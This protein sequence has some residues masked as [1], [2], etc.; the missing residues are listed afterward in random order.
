[1]HQTA[2]HGDIHGT[3]DAVSQVGS[4][5]PSWKPPPTPA[6]RKLEPS[7]RPRPP[8]VSAPGHSFVKRYWKKALILIIFCC[9]IFSLFGESEHEY[10]FDTATATISSVS[11]KNSTVTSTG[12]AFI[13]TSS[14]KIAWL[15]SFP[16]SGTSFTIDNAQQMSNLSMGTNYAQE[17][18]RPL[19][20]VRP[21]LRHDGPWLLNPDLLVPSTVMTKTHCIGFNDQG[22]LTE[23]LQTYESFERNCAR[24]SKYNEVRKTYEDSYYSVDIVSSAVHL[25]RDPISNLVARMHLGKY[26][27]KNEWKPAWTDEQVSVFNDTVE[28]VRTW[29]TLID[30]LFWNGIFRKHERALVR[31]SSSPFAQPLNET[32]MRMHLAKVP[33]NSDIFRYVQWHNLALELISKRNLSVHTIFYEDYEL[34]FEKTVADL[35]EWLR[36]DLILALGRHTATSLRLQISLLSKR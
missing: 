20:P 5:A 27:R 34:D 11:K 26:I 18:E 15:L 17:S 36:R 2:L 23:E 32:A 28:G 12:T 22:K 6:S 19:V 24:G 16:N 4:F 10:N 14:T 3:D 8:S 1:M 25:V 13:S 7:P 33:C 35:F 30:G 29:C 31:G 9:L 21:Q